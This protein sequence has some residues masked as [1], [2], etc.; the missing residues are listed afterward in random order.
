MSIPSSCDETDPEALTVEAALARVLETVQ[1]LEGAQR[2]DLHGALGRVLAQPVSAPIDVPPHAN[3]AMDGYA[4]RADELAMG[5]AFRIVGEAFAGHPYRGDIGPGECVRVM[6]G[7]VM[8]RDADTVVQQEHVR[9]E[10]ERIRVEQAPAAGANVRQAGEDIAA[11]STVLPAGHRVGSAELGLLASLGLTEVDVRRLPRVA[12][13]STGDELRSAGEALGEGEIYDSN[14]HT[15]HGLLRETGVEA[16]DLGRIPDDE[17][18]TRRVMAQA[19]AQ[20]DLIVTSGGAS[21]GAADHVTRVLREHGAAQ[22]WKIAMKPGRPLNFGRVDNAW[23][24]GLPGNPVAVMVT[25]ALFVA[26]ALRRLRGESYAAPLILRAT[27]RSALRKNPGR[28]D[29]QRGVLTQ[30]PDGTLEVETSGLQSSHILSGMSRANCLIRLPRDAGPMAAGATVD[31][32][33]FHAL[34]R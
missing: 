26:P 30:R 23:F 22:F 25:F 21:V 3:S 33:P 24:F 16:T 10:G 31:V 17:A 18:A 2:V 6:T 28:T 19:A 9:V 12:Y 13:F 5:T 1:P 11:G 32:I 8:P 27:A 4:L 20:A 29:F 15:L 7:G 14:R 34:F